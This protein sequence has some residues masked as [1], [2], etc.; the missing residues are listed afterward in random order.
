M[1]NLSL[2]AGTTKYAV[3]YVCP[4]NFGLGIFPEP[5]SEFV[6]EATVQD[7]AAFTA[8]CLGAFP[9]AQEDAATGSVNASAI[10][11][12][13]QVQVFACAMRH[14]AAKALAAYAA[15]SCSGAAVGSQGFVC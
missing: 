3:A 15:L 9:L 13:T 1:L 5:V 14:S 12:T 10:A 8:D 4:S 7:G 6:I 2:P 11:G